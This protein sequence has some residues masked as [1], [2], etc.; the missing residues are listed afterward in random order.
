MDPCS[1][2]QLTKYCTYK[3]GSSQSE[4][5]S[6]HCDSFDGERTQKHIG[7]NDTNIFSQ[8]SHRNVWLPYVAN[9]LVDEVL[10]YLDVHDRNALLRTCWNL[11][12]VSARRLYMHVSVTAYKARRFFKTIGESRMNYGMYT[13]SLQYSAASNT[14]AWLTYVLFRDALSHFPE[15]ETITLTVRSE[16][17]SLLSFI[18]KKSTSGLSM[19]EEADFET[20]GSPPGKFAL[21]RLRTLNLHG[22]LRVLKLFQ[23]RS[24][25]TLYLT[26]RL[27]EEDF[28]YFLHAV[29]TNKEGNR[30]T[31]L[32]N[33][34]ITFDEAFNTQSM[35]HI[36]K[37][38]AEQL[39]NLHKLTIRCPKINA[40]V[41]LESI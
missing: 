40:L 24:L 41:R 25:T 16:L 7:V 35:T 17:S 37:N 5:L 23:F 36:F 12:C 26:E 38:L 30:N 33:L 22:D 32:K 1:S 31:V 18:I 2:C 13:R 6:R 10:S 20:Y 21:E 3:T 15:L 27:E 19:L 34:T 4:T 29:S 11:H 8:A 14:D 39:P 9:E 28:L